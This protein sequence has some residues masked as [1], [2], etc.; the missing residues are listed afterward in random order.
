MHHL[1]I[2]MLW[3]AERNANSCPAGAV[4]TG[5]LEEV[6]LSLGF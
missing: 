1:I 5:F 3:R 6:A 4:G 2:K